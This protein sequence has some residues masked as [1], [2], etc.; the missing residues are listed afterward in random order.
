MKAFYEKVMRRLAEN[1]LTRK[2]ELEKFIYE[3][4]H[5]YCSREDFTE[6]NFHF[7]RGRSIKLSNDYNVYLPVQTRNMV[8]GLLQDTGQSLDLL[9]KHEMRAGNSERMMDP[10]HQYSKCCTAVR[11][12]TMYKSTL[13]NV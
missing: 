13:S 10:K 8:V 11:E 3:N 6:D 4:F 1:N 9:S 12:S 2:P 5:Y 7:Q